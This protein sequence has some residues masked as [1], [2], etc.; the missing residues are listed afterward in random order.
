MTSVYIV[1]TQTHIYAESAAE[2]E[3]RIRKAVER[4]TPGPVESRAVP[5]SH[6]PLDGSCLWCEWLK[7]VAGETAPASGGSG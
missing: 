5:V 6:V 1:T 7:I 3:K 4:E 2:A